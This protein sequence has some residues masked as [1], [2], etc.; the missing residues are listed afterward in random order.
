MIVFFVISGFLI[1]SI[2]LKRY[3]RNGAIGFRD[4][5][6]SR[7][8]RFAPTVG[9]VTIMVLVSALA[10]TYNWWDADSVH[11]SDMGWALPSFLTQT[12][13]V[14]LA[15]DEVIP[16]ALTPG[17]SLGVE[18]QFYVIW[19]LVMLVVL[20][21]L[22]KRAL[23]WVAFAGAAASYIWSA[24]LTYFGDFDRLEPDRIAF[25]SD[26]RGGSILLGCALAVLVTYPGVRRML[27]KFAV[28]LVIVGTTVIAVM[29]TSHV[30]D[31]GTRMTSWGQVV[32]AAFSG[33]VV[34]AL[35]VRPEAAG[36]VLTITPLVWLGQRSL[37]IFLFHVPIMMMLGGIGPEGTPTDW[38]FIS[39][40]IAATLIVTGLSYRYLDQP[41]TA[42]AK[43]KAKAKSAAKAAAKAEA[44]AKA[45][46]ASEPATEPAPVTGQTPAPV[47]APTPAPVATKDR[48]LVRT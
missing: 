14:Q 44:A 31:F 27:A 24:W 37:G 8:A 15:S 41:L 23:M 26:T 28:P 36:G 32:L 1:T 11:V 33:L 18:W 10:F 48:E 7:F 21:Y 17:W 30:F 47:A 9:L 16:F 40:V 42:W 20:S 45:G 4:F 38:V 39:I 22:G 3:E 6:Y 35:W 46:A 34:A 25:G 2:L 43:G 13:N 12:V 29:F 19:P 5:Y